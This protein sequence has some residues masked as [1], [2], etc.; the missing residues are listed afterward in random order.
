MNLIKISSTPPQNYLAEEILLGCILINPLVF[1]KVIYNITIEAFFLE[2]HQIIYLNLLH[3]YNHN[4]LHPIE[5]LYNL[6]ENRNLQKIGGIYKIIELMKQS[7]I[8]IYSNN[9]NIYIDELIHIINNNY[10]KRLIIQ[11][12]HNIIQ[13]AYIKKLN[14]HILYNK[15]SSYL[16]I[17]VDKIPKNYIHNLQTLIGNAIFEIQKKQNK[18][19]K[20][21]TSIQAIIKSGFI[22]L[23]KLIH[24]L[25]NGDL[26]I[27]AARPS[28]GKTS[29]AINIASNILKQSNYGVCIFSLEMSSKQI[30]N[31]F[32]SI[33]SQIPY[34]KIIN[35]HINSNQWK[36]ITR[37]CKKLLNSNLY[38]HDTSNVSIDYIE[39]ISK[40]W[41]Q[42][43]KNIGIIIIDYLQLI[44]TENLNHFNRVQQI[45]Y[46]TRK[47]KI[48][49]QY[50]NIPLLALSQLNRSI[51]LR[52]NKEPLL[53]DLKESGCINSDV[54]IMTQDKIKY[55]LNIY[56]IYYLSKYLQTSNIYLNKLIISQYHHTKIRSIHN[57]HLN[58]NH[59]FQLNNKNNNLSLTYN[60]KYLSK[61]YWIE[62]H[63]HVE[64]QIISTIY[65]LFSTKS[66]LEYKYILHVYYL[67]YTTVYDLQMNLYIHF[68]CNNII[69]HNSIEQ[70]A[71]IIMM[72]YEKDNLL[73]L[74]NEKIIDI[75]I[76]KNRNGPIGSCQLVFSLNNTTFMDYSD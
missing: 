66:L 58:F 39:Y 34:D 62:V 37:V 56:Y 64:K 53:S 5:L 48:L 38:I 4:K 9:T 17:T 19:T 67:K 73:H 15:A 72:L 14:S 8:F 13:L 31:K 33:N 21:S 44:Q 24:G 61:Y 42:D 40:I 68:I 27:L 30:L 35:A 55:N 11:Y 59:I 26:I 49:A 47:L 54:S 10:T 29:L 52:I 23:D 2:S 65:N 50:L 3:I 36:S 20:T 51:E 22:D 32:I 69:I 63:K 60:H 16:N 1:S 70:D 43:N 41:I 57:I 74:N 6:S 46:I 7:Q 12:G 75:T 28:M 18:V 25:P 76:S 45:S 71:D